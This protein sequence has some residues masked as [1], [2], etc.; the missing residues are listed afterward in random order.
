[1]KLG[2][3]TLVWGMMAFGATAMFAAD[4]TVNQSGEWS[5]DATWGGTNPGASVDTLIFGSANLALTADQDVSVATVDLKKNGGSIVIAD[6]K[7]FTLTSGFNAD[8]SSKNNSVDFSGKGTLSFNSANGQIGLKYGLYNFNTAVNLASSKGFFNNDVNNAQ[9]NINAD[10]NANGM[11]SAYVGIGYAGSLNINSGTT[12]LSGVYAYTDNTTVNVAEGATLQMVDGSS[13]TIG[14]AIANGYIDGKINANAWRVSNKGY[15]VRFGSAFEG[16]NVYGG[17]VSI[18]STAEVASRSGKEGDVQ[19]DYGFQF[20]GGKIDVYAQKDKL[21][22]DGKVLF[23]NYAGKE[24]VITLNT[25]NA[26][27]TTGTTGQGATTFAIG[28]YD[29]KVKGSADVKVVLN[30]DNDFGTIDFFSANTAVANS[31]ANDSTLTLQ[32]NGKNVVIGKLTADG[33]D[34]KAGYKYLVLESLTDF[35]VELTDITGINMDS[36]AS[37]AEYEVYSTS[38]I[39]VL[40]GSVLANALIVKQLESGKY[41]INAAS[42]IPEPATYAAIFGALALGLAIIRRR[43]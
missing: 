21:T 15:T 29:N 4:A 27:K 31:S 34:L 28:L 13:W 14:F 33:G 26:I 32:T 39:G 25:T 20:V 11:Q 2:T 35:T 23:G 40:K 7:T 5:N 8:N 38:N 42:P 9:V 41:Y 24:T 19:R 16:S 6:G 1:M 30:A 10:Y 3:R 17:T 43:K 36:V 22:S 12:K 18:S 37:N